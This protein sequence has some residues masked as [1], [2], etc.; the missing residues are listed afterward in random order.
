MAK[1]VPSM[2]EFQSPEHPE[3]AEWVLDDEH[4]LDEHVLEEDE[5][6]PRSRQLPLRFF[7]SM[8]L[9]GVAL[10]L[11]WRFSGVSQLADQMWS[12]FKSPEAPVALA[13]QSSGGPPPQQTPELDALKAEIGRLTAVNRQ[14]AAEITTLKDQQRELA[15][16]AASPASTANLFSN[17]TL[18]KLQIVPRTLTTGTASRVPRPHP[19]A[20]QKR[21]TG[22][23]PRP[24]T[25]R[26]RW[27]RRTDGSGNRPAA[28]R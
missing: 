19:R 14:M 11:V 2:S 10:A 6:Q 9:L 17:P 24:A 15:R 28:L 18:L 4:V 7:F 5:Q 23:P 1:V 27:A 20:A 22:R 12:G 16:R 13:A 21:V 25:H 8:A 3:A 26:L